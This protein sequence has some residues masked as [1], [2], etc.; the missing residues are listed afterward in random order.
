MHI[1][2]EIKS[3]VESIQA[4][5]QHIYVIAM[6][7]GHSSRLVYDTDGKL[8]LFTTCLNSELEFGTWLGK[9]LFH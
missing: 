4:P 6:R 1:K 8:R 5:Q 2:C 7:K 3:Q 9:W